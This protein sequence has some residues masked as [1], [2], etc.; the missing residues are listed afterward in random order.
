MKIRI[1]STP[2]G[3]PPKWVREAWVNLELDTLGIQDLSD[4][5]TDFFQVDYMRRNDNENI[6]GYRISHETAMK[7]IAAT[8]EKAAKW[9][10]KNDDLMF[11]E[12][13]FAEKC[14]EV[15]KD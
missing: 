5:N 14:C 7:A 3:E 15:V 2:T 8:N 9:W 12:F 11:D 1:V 13:I 6:G 10:K 4:D